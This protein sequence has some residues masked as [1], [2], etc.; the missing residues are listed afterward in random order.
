L[1]QATGASAFGQSVD[2]EL[3]TQLETS[4]MLPPTRTARIVCRTPSRSEELSA[5]RSPFVTT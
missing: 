4:T 5:R 3:F 2:S 1:T